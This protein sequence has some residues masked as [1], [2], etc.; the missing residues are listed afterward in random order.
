MFDHANQQ[1][2]YIGKGED[3][4]FLQELMAGGPDYRI[5][6]DLGG[7]VL[8][9]VGDTREERAAFDVVARRVIANEGQ[10]YRVRLKHRGSDDADGHYDRL[11]ID[12]R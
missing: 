2:G 3:V 10:G 6:P 11:I 12:I 7:A 4:G 5:V 9:P 1:R 8:G